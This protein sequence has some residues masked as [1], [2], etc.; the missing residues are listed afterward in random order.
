MTGFVPAPS[1]S[2]RIRSWPHPGSPGWYF[3]RDPV[4]LLSALFIAATA[5]LIV[6]APA[7]TDFAAQG[8]GA[9]DTANRLL[10]PTSEHLFGTDHLGRDLWARV[11]FGGRVSMSIAV[12]V[13]AL[14]VVIG[15]PLGILA[16]YAGGWLDE[17]I[18]RITDVF[19]AFPPL[20]LAV[21]LAA[22][23]GPG[24]WNM[25]LAI[26]LGWWPWY[27][28]IARAQVV[29][30]RQRPFVEAAQFMGVSNATIMRRHLAPFVIGPVSIQATLDFGSAVLTA[31][32]LSFLGLGMVPPT[33]D[34]GEMV[35]AGRAYFPDRWWYVVFPGLA[36]FLVALAFNLLGD[37]LR[38]AF[39]PKRRG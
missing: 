11:L 15:M 17:V 4:G 19:L 9:P 39:A 5:V 26:S 35:N 13:V 20:L 34:W 30:L 16:G 28:R 14:A 3:L 22:L 25:V 29:S 33:P 1:K 12:T 6:F 18:M 37:S 27:T 31:S 23:L 21:F 2:R 38:A 7:F 36:I 32:A 24:F 8:L 10:P